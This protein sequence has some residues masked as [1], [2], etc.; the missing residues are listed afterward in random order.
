MAARPTTA[1]GDRGSAAAELAVLD[2]PV[3]AVFRLGWPP[4][5]Y[6]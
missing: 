4:R 3:L 6:P 1:P 5:T 2:R